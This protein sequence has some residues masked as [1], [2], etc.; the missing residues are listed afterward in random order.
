M[1]DALPTGVIRVGAGSE[2][3]GKLASIPVWDDLQAVKETWLETLDAD[4]DE[5]D[6]DAVGRDQSYSFRNFRSEVSFTAWLQSTAP[7]ETF[8]KGD[9]IQVASAYTPST[10]G[11]RIYVVKSAADAG[12]QLA[13]K[14]RKWALTM[15]YSPTVDATQST[16]T[17]TMFT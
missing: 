9:R 13:G 12:G 7:H 2:A 15:R 5:P 4:E 11:S 1:S 16:S 6:Q 17:R 3:S 8:Q 14:T 10:E